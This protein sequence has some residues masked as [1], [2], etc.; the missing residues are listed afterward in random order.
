MLFFKELKRIKQT[1]INED[2]SNPIND[3]QIKSFLMNINNNNTD[4]KDNNNDKEFILLQ[5]NAYELQTE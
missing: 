4:Y 1:I 2:F 3:T 5:S